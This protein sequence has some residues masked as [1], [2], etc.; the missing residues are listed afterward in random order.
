[1]KCIMYKNKKR[2]TIDI[3]K[4][5]V[6]KQAKDPKEYDSG[7]LQCEFCNILENFNNKSGAPYLYF[8]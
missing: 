7:M 3:L 8:V 6:S 2:H 5:I 4:W 1:M